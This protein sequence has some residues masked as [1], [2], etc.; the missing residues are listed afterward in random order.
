MNLG[1]NSGA[2][3]GGNKGRSSRL[4]V[5]GVGETDGPGEVCS[6]AGTLGQ[7]FTESRE[8]QR[9]EGRRV[10]WGALRIDQERGR[11]YGQLIIHSILMTG[12]CVRVCVCVC[13]CVKKAT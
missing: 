3:D 11:D 13:V 9:G 8:G 1:E 10:L 12:V 5:G 4:V 2:G 7:W 6:H